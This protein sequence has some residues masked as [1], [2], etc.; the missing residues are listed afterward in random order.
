EASQLTAAPIDAGL[1]AKLV[2]CYVA[3]DA[4]R[5][6][7]RC[8]PLVA[9]NLIGVPPALINAAEHYA[10]NPQIDAYAD[11]LRAAHVPV[12]LSRYAGMTHGFVH[13]FALLDRGRDAVVECSAALRTA[14]AKQSDG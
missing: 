8:S 2:A 9:K 13:A 12:T 1:L 7:P 4:D 3:N 10:L 6:D 5:E 11:A 14:F